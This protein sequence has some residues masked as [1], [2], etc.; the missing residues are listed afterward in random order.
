MK[1]S[2]Q[3]RQFFVGIY[4]WAGNSVIATT[5]FLAILIV[6]PFSRRAVYRI[7]RAW[8][9][10][11]GSWFQIEFK[12]RDDS[13]G[14][15][16]PPPYLFIPLNQT[17][18]VDSAIGPWYLPLHRPI[19]NIEYAMVPFIGWAYTL[20]GSIVIVRQWKSQAKRGIERAVRLLQRGENVLVSIEGRR[21][22]DGS[23]SAYKKGP[24]VLAIRTGATIIP[25]LHYGAR[26]V[27]RPGTWRIEPGT[28]ELEICR[29][30]QTRGLQYEDRNALVEQLRAIA[31]EK[32]G[33]Q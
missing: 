15:W 31:E 2:F 14:N 20:L 16:G 23:I 4:R 24:A 26:R 21:S 29:P 11:S 12:V 3:L 32:L 22:P 33:S 8:S 7:M 17:S 25:M 27:W 10:R 18:L 5:H 6:A 1:E 30:I 28:I 9:R 13:G 19:I